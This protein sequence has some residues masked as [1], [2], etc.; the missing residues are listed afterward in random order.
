MLVER[1]VKPPQFGGKP[2]LRFRIALAWRSAHPVH[3]TSARRI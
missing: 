2:G 1:F 3:E